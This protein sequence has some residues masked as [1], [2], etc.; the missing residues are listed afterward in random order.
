MALCN[1]AESVYVYFWYNFIAFAC[2]FKYSII[3]ILG[4][5]S[6]KAKLLQYNFVEII[7]SY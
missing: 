1:T 5:L 2:T 3:Y 4:A 6:D 7:A